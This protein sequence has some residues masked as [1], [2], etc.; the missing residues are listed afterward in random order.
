[1]S[2][3]NFFL[4]SLQQNN[5][6]PSCVKFFMLQKSIISFK[7]ACESRSQWTAIIPI[8]RGLTRVFTVYPHIDVPQFQ[9]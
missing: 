5:F 8:D 9:T 6:V 4:C 1:M 7:F 2:F 3:T